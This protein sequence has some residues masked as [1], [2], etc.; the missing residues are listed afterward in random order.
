LRFRRVFDEIEKPGPRGW[1]EAALAAGYFDQPQ[2]ARDF[3][4]YLGMSS[5]QWVQQR[6]GLAKA[7][8]APETY[9]KRRQ[10]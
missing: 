9:K 4:R 7:L 1:V 3:R 2:M 10:D 5:R 8:T 6:A